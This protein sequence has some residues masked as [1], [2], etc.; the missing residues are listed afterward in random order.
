M[1]RPYTVMEWQAATLFRYD[2]R[3]R[4]RATNEQGDPPAPRVFV[5]RTA[6]GNLWRFRHDLPDTLVR[7][8]DR[9]L[10]S[11]PTVTDL[12]QPLHCFDRLRDALA[13]HAPIAGMYEGPAWRC[14]EGIV[15]PRAV[16]VTRLTDAAAAART[17]PWLVTELAFV[18]PCM[19]VLHE[20]EAVA[21]CFSS[22]FSPVAAEA[23]VETLGF[24]RRRGYAAA[25]AAAWAGAVRALGRLPLYSTSW[26]NLASQGVAASLGLIL[27]GTDLSLL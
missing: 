1:L 7:D 16:P 26:D 20:G 24:H 6:E 2:A 10:A 8:L 14:P 13:A 15:A 3:G 27:Y 21:L 22:R 12:R 23:G 9:M 11:E 17:F 19:A 18:E 5:G 25:A 4:L